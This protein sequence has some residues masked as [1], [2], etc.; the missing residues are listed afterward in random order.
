MPRFLFIDQP[1]KVYFPEDSDWDVR[2][3]QRGEDREAV[4]RMYALSLKVVEEL[5][6]QFQV[7]ITDHANINEGWFQNCIVERWREGVKLVPPDWELGG[8]LSLE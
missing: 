8:Q 2:D 3:G 1:Y 7:I 5:A 4:K 6:P